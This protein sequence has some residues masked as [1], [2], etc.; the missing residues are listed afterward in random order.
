MIRASHI[1]KCYG[2]KMA[3]ADVSF[4]VQR[5]E[6]LGFIGPNGA[7][8]S[9]TIKMLSGVLPVWSGKVEIGGYDIMENPMKAKALTGYLPENA[10]LPPNMTVTEFLDYTATVH[11]LT[12]K[13]KR[14]AI[15]TAVER[16]ALGKVTDQEIETLS[17][18]Y[19][20]RV[21]FAQAIL[22]TPP[23]LMLDEPTDGLDPNQK[24]E[25]RNLIQ[26]LRRDTAII[27]STHILEE[28][29]SVCTRVLLLAHGKIVFSGP[30]AAFTA[31]QEQLRGTS[32]KISPE[33][34][35]AAAALMRNQF[36]GAGRLDGTEF[37]IP[38][39]HPDL[40]NIRQALHSAGITILSESPSVTTLDDVFA[41]LTVESEKTEPTE[42]CKSVQTDAAP[43]K[44]AA[45]DDDDD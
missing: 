8:K 22:H 42:E 29:R 19:K 44:P 24:R 6:V 5:G 37:I 39:A 23:V 31:M 43:E 9:T 38:A 40:Q 33:N 28:I 14:A 35:A 13:D 34:V 15:A 25:I 20:R 27:I 10:P 11:G 18:G 36:P 12:G 26:T 2:T 41:S 1:S 21:C 30:T 7:G 32:L 16:C 17:K 3:V 4:S 45:G